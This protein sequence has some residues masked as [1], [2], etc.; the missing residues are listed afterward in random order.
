MKT[1]PVRSSLTVLVLAAAFFATSAPGQPAP[2]DSD[3]AWSDLEADLMN[4]Q[5]MRAVVDMPSPL[6]GPRRI[7][8]AVYGSSAGQL[9]LDPLPYGDLRL[10]YHPH[11][12]TSF[13]RGDQ[14]VPTEGAET[15]ENVLAELWSAIR[16]GKAEAMAMRP[17][18]LPAGVR[19]E[20]KYWA[21]T[22][23]P[24]SE[25]KVLI[26]FNKVRPTHLVIGSDVVRIEQME[27][28]VDLPRDALSPHRVYDDGDPLAHWHRENQEPDC[29]MR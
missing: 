7:R 23:L 18:L 10:R 1:N 6:R 27:F 2:A 28:D 26:A 22:E 21:S 8:A 24:A 9:T 25:L 11:E 29:G 17:P 14:V 15:M 3:L 16:E 13:T 20:G 19:N 12:G 4:F 5:T